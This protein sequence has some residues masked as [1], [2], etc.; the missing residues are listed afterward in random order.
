VTYLK[1][2]LREGDKIFIGELGYMPAILHY[3][4]AYPEGRYQS[5]PFGKETDKGIEFEKPFVYQNRIFTIYYSRICCDQYT[6]DGSRLWIVVGK[7]DAKKLK[8]NSP[9]AFRGYFDG[10]FLN[11]NKFPYDASMFLFLFDPKSPNE[12][13]LEIP[14]E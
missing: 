3:F 7:G 4:G 6:S 12:K 13:G 11:L 2:H 1:S 14:I 9:F 10:S 8:A 5:I